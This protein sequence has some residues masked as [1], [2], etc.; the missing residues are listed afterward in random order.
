MSHFGY[1]G[2]HLIVA[3][4]DHIPNGIQWLGDVQWGHL[5]THVISAV[6]LGR[7]RQ[8]EDDRFVDPGVCSQRW[9]K[10]ANNWG[11]NHRH[12]RKDHRGC[13]GSLLK[14]WAVPLKWTIYLQING[15]FWKWTIYLKINGIP[16][17]KRL[18]SYGEIH[19]FFMG[20]STISM[21]IFSSYV[22]LPEG[23]L[24]MDNL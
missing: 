3:I 14:K 23:I 9:L 6:F 18:H 24:K 19:Q 5:M 13:E 11:S 21:A 10:L 4:I 1:I 16:S 2:H 12:P 22:K 8:D 15:I 7:N 20:K 17:G